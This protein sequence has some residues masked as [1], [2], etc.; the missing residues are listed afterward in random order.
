M[1]ITSDALQYST[2]NHV[3]AIKKITWKQ[4]HN[5]K[6]TAKQSQ[7]IEYKDGQQIEKCY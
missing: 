3:V 5:Y 1:H 7:A 4:A 2:P 6:S